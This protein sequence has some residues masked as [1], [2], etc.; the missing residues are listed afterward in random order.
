MDFEFDLIQSWIVR[1][2]FPFFRISTLMMTMPIFGTDFVPKKIKIAIS[3]VL[4]IFFLNFDSYDPVQIIKFSPMMIFKEIMIG[5]SI[6]LTA[7]IFFQVIIAAGE[8]ISFQSSL[9][10]ASLMDPATKFHIPILS[11]IYQVFFFMVYLSMNGH[12]VLFQVIF[13]SFKVFPTSDSFFFLDR[14]Y[15]IFNWFSW[16]LKGGVLAVLPIVVSLLIVNVS[17]GVMTKA[18]PQINILSIGFPVY[19]MFLFIFM[20]FTIVP[21]YDFFQYMH[22]LLLEQFM[23]IL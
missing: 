17:L 13:D 16:I 15:Y 21:F 9:A 19:M 11:E 3:F 20:L 23:N 5:F 4:V 8:V 18:V 1:F 10:F 6:G 12:M 2:I 14:F 7:Q 22:H